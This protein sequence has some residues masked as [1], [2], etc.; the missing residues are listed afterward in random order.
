MLGDLRQADISRWF[1]VSGPNTVLDDAILSSN[2]DGI[3]LKL[4]PEGGWNERNRI[5]AASNSGTGVIALDFDVP[6]HRPRTRPHDTA[7]SA[8]SSAAAQHQRRHS[9]V[10]MW[11]AGPNSRS[12]SS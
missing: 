8:C 2:F 11:R 7:Y 5:K 6:W 10:S 9:L 4:D 3:A 1:A 12:P